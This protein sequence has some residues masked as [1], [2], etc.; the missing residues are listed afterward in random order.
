MVCLLSTHFI[1]LGQFIPVQNIGQQA[2]KK[3]CF[4]FVMAT[5]LLSAFN[6]NNDHTTGFSHPLTSFS[7]SS[8]GTEESR[9]FEFLNKRTNLGPAC[10]DG[11]F[12]DLCY[13]MMLEHRDLIE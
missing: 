9:I 8:F 12:C 3:V 10:D 4:T 7:S 5:D 6:T 13:E 11:K 2:V 1:E